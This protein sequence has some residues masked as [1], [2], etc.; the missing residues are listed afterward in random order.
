MI[1]KEK[2]HRV[3]RVSYHNRLWYKKGNQCKT[4]G[5]NQRSIESHVRNQTT[6]STSWWGRFWGFTTML[7]LWKPTLGFVLTRRILLKPSA[8]LEQSNPSALIGRSIVWCSHLHTPPLLWI[9]ILSFVKLAR[10][11]NSLVVQLFAEFGFYSKH[12]KWVLLQ[13]KSILTILHYFLFNLA[14]LVHHPTMVAQ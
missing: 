5:S 3:N 14:Y 12:A 10:N 13:Y 1:I 6:L 2:E 7:Y 9:P 11:S 8:R 4:R